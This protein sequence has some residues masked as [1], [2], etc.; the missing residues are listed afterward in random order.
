MTA[1]L[2]VAQAVEQRGPVIGSTDLVCYIS[3]AYPELRF[4][5]EYNHIW[6]HFV[7][8]ILLNFLVVRKIV[9]IQ[10]D[11]KCS[12]SDAST[13]SSRQYSQAR[14]SSIL[15]KENQQRN[16]TDIRPIEL[17]QRKGRLTS[18][19]VI[20]KAIIVGFG[21]IV[22]WIPSTASRVLA[23]IPGGTTPLSLKYAMAVSMGL[24]GIWNP[25]AYFIVRLWNGS[26]GS[27]Q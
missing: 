23:M 9:Q 13:N 16:T 11:V 21:F 12:V 10:A 3:A 2:F 20:V 15:C 17:D 19:K 24:H 22:S 6:L 5:V 26:A 1:G 25:I 14:G 4:E 7:G 27:K 18:R 8:V